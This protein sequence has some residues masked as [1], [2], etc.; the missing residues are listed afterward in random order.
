MAPVLYTICFAAG[1]ALA[2]LYF[3]PERYRSPFRG[4]VA[5]D[6]ALIARFRFMLRA[7]RVQD[8]TPSFILLGLALASGV[9]GLFLAVILHNAVAL[10]IGPVFVAAG[11]YAYLLRR[12]GQLT[13]NTAEELV[14]FLRRMQ[15][16]VAVGNSWQ[17]AFRDAVIESAALRP[18]LQRAVDDIALGIPPI[19]AVKASKKQLPLKTWEIVVNQLEIFDTHGGNL[20][21]G[22]EALVKHIDTLVT[23]QRMGRAAHA[24]F[25]LQQKMALGLGVGVIVFFMNRLDP[26]MVHKMFTTPLGIIASLFGVGLVGGG[27][28][29]MRNSIH[30]IDKELNF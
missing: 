30:A 2:L 28:F 14:P 3:A 24:S 4:L 25:A 19:E 22:L 17:T 5:D 9:L 11:T 23:L 13:K 8:D 12:T 27:W 21:K 15:N 29:V 7:A 26:V 18:M 1:V 10:L 16:A 20:P 6:S